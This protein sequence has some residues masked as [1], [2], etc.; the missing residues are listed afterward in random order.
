MRKIHFLVYGCKWG[1]KY[2]LK[3]SLRKVNY[4]WLRNQT[5]CGNLLSVRHTCSDSC[6]LSLK[7]RLSHNE[8]N[9]KSRCHVFKNCKKNNASIKSPIIFANKFRAFVNTRDRYLILSRKVTLTQI[10]KRKEIPSNDRFARSARSGRA[11]GL[12]TTP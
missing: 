10:Q 11:F 12:K 7:Y 3:P 9:A 8:M 2:I 4:P 5:F 6:E 1:L